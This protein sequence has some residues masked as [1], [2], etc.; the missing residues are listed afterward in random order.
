MLNASKQLWRKAAEDKFQIKT[1]TIPW[2]LTGEIICNWHIRKSR[3]EK[4]A[5]EVSLKGKGVEAQQVPTCR[6]QDTREEN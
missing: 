4:R 1:C 5:P 2:G 3:R 6:A